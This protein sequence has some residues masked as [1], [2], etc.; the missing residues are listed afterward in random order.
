MNLFK[1]SIDHTKCLKRPDHWIGSFLTAI[2]LAG[3]YCAAKND[4]DVTK[5][6]ESVISNYK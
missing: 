1:T 2:L 4:V 5:K 6:I 3:L